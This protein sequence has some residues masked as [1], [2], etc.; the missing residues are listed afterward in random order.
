MA[1]LLATGNHFLGHSIKGECRPVVFPPVS[2]C[3]Y[4]NLW[5]IAIKGKKTF[6]YIS[7]REFSNWSMEFSCHPCSKCPV[8]H[9]VWVLS[10]VKHHTHI[11]HNYI[12]IHRRTACGNSTMP[13]AIRHVQYLSWSFVQ[14][15]IILY[16]K[17]LPIRQILWFLFL[18]LWINFIT[19]I[20]FTI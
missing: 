18:F 14:H 8:A 17:L 3:S 13:Y 20:W 9:T 19:S 16:Y 1:C 6:Y 4:I 2:W 12:I 15:D 7:P 10:F 5:C 11:P